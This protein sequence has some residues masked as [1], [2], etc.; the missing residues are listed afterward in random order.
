VAPT[1]GW[2]VFALGHLAI[3]E[4]RAPR[5]QFVAWRRRGHDAVGPGTIRLFCRAEL[6]CHPLLVAAGGTVRPD[7]AAATT[8]PRLGVVGRSHDPDRQLENPSDPGLSAGPSSFR[9]T[10]PAVGRSATDRPG[11]DGAIHGCSRGPRA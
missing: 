2:S 10:G 7:Q 4:T 8:A 3:V 11:A 5:R 9:R 1:P 6:Q